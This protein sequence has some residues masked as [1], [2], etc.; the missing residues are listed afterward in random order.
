MK[1]PSQEVSGPQ[2]A[3]IP[4][5]VIELT[6]ANVMQIWR[7]SL[8]NL[9]DLTS[10]YAKKAES[11]AII[12]PNR[13]VV[14][15]PSKYNFDKSSCERPERKQSLESALREVTGQRIVLSFEL[16]EGDTAPSAQSQPAAQNSRQRAREVEQH[17][18][19]QKAAEVFDAEIVRVDAPL[20]QS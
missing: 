3:Q 9:D 12:A 19:I 16:V 7:E 11:L 6:D 10:D 1:P 5:K 13:L 17:P 4:E 20:K 18:L 15:F 2:L 14:R 8:G